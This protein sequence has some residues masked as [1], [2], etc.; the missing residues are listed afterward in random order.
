MKRPFQRKKPAWRNWQ[1][2]WTHN[3]VAARPCGF[4]PLRRQG[5]SLSIRGWMLGVGCL[6]TR[7]RLWAPKK[8][9]RCLQPSRKAAAWLA[10]SLGMTFPQGGV[11]SN[12]SAGSADSTSRF[13]TLN[14]QNQNFGAAQIGRD[15]E[16]NL[17]P[18]GCLTVSNTSPLNR[19][20]F[21]ELRLFVPVENE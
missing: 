1:T 18:A 13:S 11:G 17:T 14:A 12:P 3:P 16:A 2:R 5:F 8:I 19:Q 6:K 4:E 20:V 10:T 15:G 7:A 9:E 21:W